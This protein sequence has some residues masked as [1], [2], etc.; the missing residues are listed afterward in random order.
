MNLKNL[1]LCLLAVFQLKAADLAL[2][3][4]T[5]ILGESDDGVVKTFQV[6]FRVTNSTFDF[7]EEF[8]ARI[9]GAVVASLSAPDELLLSGWAFSDDATY[10]GIPAGTSV[11][12]QEVSIRCALAD[13]AIVESALLADTLLTGS[14]QIASFTYR[15]LDLSFSPPIFVSAIDQGDGKTDLSYQF[16]S[17]TNLADV[18]F[19]AA[20]PVVDEVALNPYDVSLVSTAFEVSVQPESTR[21]FSPQT[22]TLSV[23]TAHLAAVRAL[24]ENDGVGIRVEASEVEEDA[25]NVYTLSQRSLSTAETIYNN[26]L[27]VGEDRLTLAE[28]FPDSEDENRQIQPGFLRF[29]WMPNEA[30][31]QYSRVQVGDYLKFPSTFFYVLANGEAGAGAVAAPARNSHGNMIPDFYFQITDKSLNSETGLVEINAEYVRYHPNVENGSYQTVRPSLSYESPARLR[32]EPQDLESVFSHGKA[33]E[34]TYPEEIRRQLYEGEGES[35][36]LIDCSIVPGGDDALAGQLFR[37]QFDVDPIVF[38][39]LEI[40]PGVVIS[41]QVLIRAMDLDVQMAWR[42][43]KPIQIEATQKSSLYLN[44]IVES[45]GGA[46]NRDEPDFTSKIDLFDYD[47]PL[48]TYQIPPTFELACSTSADIDVGADVFLPGKATI[49]INTAIVVGGRTTFY[50]GQ[51]TRESIKDISPPLVSTSE[52]QEALKA[53]V[54]AW[55]SARFDLTFSLGASGGESYGFPPL[56]SGTAFF[57]ARAEA[58]FQLDPLGDPWWSMEAGLNTFMGAETRIFDG[59]P[60]A[61]EEIQIGETLPLFSDQSDGPLPIVDGLLPSIGKDLRWATVLETFESPGAKPRIE[62]T[63]DDG[64][65]VMSRVRSGRRQIAKLDSSGRTSVAKLLP[66]HEAGRLSRAR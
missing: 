24:I 52:L 66:P 28:A 33:Y 50:K 62:R 1:L 8:E 13:A 18:R 21:S 42:E 10:F 36:P 49:P 37:S 20:S 38:N 17:L 30:P 48:F 29:T 22:V 45:R 44:L 15:P 55:L 4:D 6:E 25:P 54:L 34:T 40:I 39:E 23:D 65:I 64:C 14:C 2:P 12:G 32:A 46:D 16:T 60:F 56:I 47:F 27:L 35:D 53:Q 58:D 3:V 5:T 59:E 57:R 7:I 41:G 43:S 26:T 63:S 9:D 51:I 31:D 61:A 19:V 11:S